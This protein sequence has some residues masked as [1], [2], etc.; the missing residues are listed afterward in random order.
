MGRHFWNVKP[1]D[2]V[3]KN[4]PQYPPNTIFQMAQI[5]QKSESKVGNFPKNP[6]GIFYQY[7]QMINVNA[8]DI[9]ITN[10]FSVFLYMIQIPPNIIFQMA[11]ILQKSESKVGPDP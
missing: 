8:Q 1:Q 9:V 2:K 11:H 5:L 4:I 3:I 6:I 7:F 10:K